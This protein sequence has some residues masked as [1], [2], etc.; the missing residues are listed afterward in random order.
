[1]M[2]ARDLRE[3]NLIFYNGEEMIVNIACDNFSQIHNCVNN[4]VITPIPLAEEWLLKS[5]LKEEVDKIYNMVCLPSG[6][7]GDLHGATIF[8]SVNCLFDVCYYKGKYYLIL[9][10][11]TDDYGDNYTFIEV[12]HVH[13]FQN[14]YHALTNEELTIK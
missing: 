5:G 14:L 3:E 4:G 10:Y 12:E 11:S 8:S 9:S 7:E 6:G 1:M 13:K 2:K